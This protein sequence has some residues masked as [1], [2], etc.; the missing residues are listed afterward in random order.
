MQTTM[1]I[2]DFGRIGRLVLR[3]AIA[4]PEVEGKAVDDPFMDLKFMVYQVKYDSVHNRFPGTIAMPTTICID[5]HADHHGHQWLRPHR[6]LS[7]PRGHRQPEEWDPGS[8][9]SPPGLVGHVQPGE[10][11]QLAQ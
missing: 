10:V 9:Q 11:R 7:F 3:A 1:G 2:N 6:S 5:R 4:N 8:I